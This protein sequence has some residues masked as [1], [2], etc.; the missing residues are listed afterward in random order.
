MNS[1]QILMYV[2]ALILGMLLANMLKDI[3]RCKLVEGKDNHCPQKC[4]DGIASDS[5]SVK[6]LGKCYEAGCG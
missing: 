1:E 2:V 5:L 4:I 6:A 3:Y